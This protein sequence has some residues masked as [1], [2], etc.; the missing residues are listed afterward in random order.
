MN[1]CEHRRVVLLVQQEHDDRDMYVE[2]LHHAGLTPVPV[3]TAGEGLDLARHADV[4]VT[5]LMLP[6]P[7]D[8]I[9][10][11]AQ[12]KRDDWT[13]RI[14]V[15]ALTTCAWEGQRERAL[16]AGCDVFLAKPCLPEVLVHEIRRLLSDGAPKRSSRPHA[17]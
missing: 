2:F 13:K 15:I 7:L 10:F 3:S 17:A 11:V 9:A 4:I 1:S 6:G 14:P 12:L 8:G 16:D 5:G